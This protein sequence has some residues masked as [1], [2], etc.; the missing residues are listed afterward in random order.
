MS[1]Q[2][3]EVRVLEGTKSEIYASA[4]VQVQRAN[5]NHPHCPLFRVGALLGAFPYGYGNLVQHVVVPFVNG[6]LM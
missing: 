4:A 5:Q 2:F 1:F 6:I 3:T